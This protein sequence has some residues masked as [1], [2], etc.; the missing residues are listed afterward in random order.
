MANHGAKFVSVNLNK[1]YGQQNQPSHHSHHPHFNGGGGGSYGQAAAGRGRPK[2][3]P[4]LSVPP[5][6]NLPSLRKEHEKF[7]VLGSGGAGV[8]AGTGSGSRPN[9]S[10]VG[11]TKNVAAVAEKNEAGDVTHVVEE[12]NA[13]T[14]ASSRG[15]GS[16]MPPSARS[17]GSGFIGSASSTSRDFPPSVEKTVFLRGEDF[18]SLQAA[19]PVSSGASQKQKDGL[20]QKQKQVLREESVHD[21]ENNRSGSV[22][23]MH[24]L[25]Q[26]SRNARLVEN[27]GEGR[28]MGSGHMADQIR[29]RE[30]YLPD[31]LPLVHMNPRSDWADD[32]RD[33]GH[34]FVGHGRD[35]GFSNS[36]SYWDRDFDLP[37]PTILP[38][39]PPALNQYG[40]WG[41]RDNETGK[42]F[43]SE[44]PRTDP[45]NKEVRAPSREGEEVNKWRN[46]PVSKDGFSSQEIGGYRV[47]PGSRQAGHNNN[48]LK[49]SGAML[50]RDSAFGRQHQQRNSSMESFNNRGAERNHRDYHVTEQH[51]RYRGDNFQNNS[52]SKSSLGSSGRMPPITDPILTMGR[53]KRFS[54]S[55]RPFSE[56]P[57][58]RDYGFA[59]FGERDMFSEGIVG[60]IKR[61][62]DA[63][64]STDFYDPVRE[65]FEAE[66]EKVQKMRELEK[67]RI[68]EEQER[69]LEQVQRE[70]EERQR[71]IR[72]EEERQR[73]L[74]EEARE[75]VWRAEQEKLEAIQKAEELRI[76]REE[77]RRR[78]QLEEERRKQAAKQKL[79]ELEA[80]IAKRQAEAASKL[81]SN[82]NL[83]TAAK[84]TVVIS[85][86]V[87]LH[88]EQNQKFERLELEERESSPDVMDQEFERLELEER[89]SPG[90]MDNMV[91]GFDE[92]V[93]VVIP[94]D[95]F[96]KKIGST[97]EERGTDVGISSDEQNLLPA[98]DFSEISA[99]DSSEISAD[100]SSWKVPEESTLEVSI[101]QHAGIPYSSETSDLLLDVADSSGSATLAAQQTVSAD[102][103][104]SS[105]SANSAAAQ[106]T[107][108][109]SAD[110]ITGATSHTNNT[111]SLS[112]I[113]GQGDLPLKLQFGL[114][115]GPSLIPSPVPAIQIGS[116]QMPL[117]IHPPSITHMHQSQPSMF[118]F[119]QL[120]YTSPISQGL[121]PMAP[122]SMS[123][124][125]PNMLGHINLN[126]NMR[127]TS[128]QNVNK[129]EVPSISMNKQPSFV[130]ASPEQS[131]LSRPQQ[132]NTVLNAN[133]HAD[134]SVLR[135]D[136]MKS[137]SSSQAEEK[138][139][140]HA[141]AP[142]S[143]LPSSKARGSESH[144]HHVQPVMQPPGGER[145]FIGHRGV[146]PL[147]GGG[148][149]GRR[150]TYAVK[151]AN[152]RSFGQDY[153]MP[154]D[155]NG[156]QRR[157]RRTVQRTEFRVRENNDRRPS[158]QS[159]SSNNA[160]FEDKSNYVGKAVGVFTRSGSKRGTFVPNKIPRQRIESE[161]SASGNIVSQEV[162]SG[163]RA[164]KETAKDLSI[165]SQYSSTSHHG[166]TSLRR[167]ASEEDVDAPLQ[168]GVVRV[169][170]QPGIEAP[171]DEDDF[172]EVRSKR[173]MLNDRREQREKE[174]KAQSRVTKP[175]RKPRVSRQKDV[176][177]S[178]SHN[179]LSEPL[180]SGET[181][182]T[183]VEFT[184]SEIPP[185]ANNEVATKLT[186]AACQ[187]PIG[188]PAI[189]SEAQAINRSPHPG[190]VSLVSSGSTEREPALIFDSKNKVMSLSQTQIDEA[191]KPA[192]YD[193]H[194]SAVGSHSTSVTDPVL[195]T[196]SI[197]TKDK[198]FSSGA[199]P[200]NSLLAGEKIQ[201]GAVTSPTLL[202][203]T[204][205]V[206]SH[207]IGAPGSNRTD[208]QM[209]RNFPVSEKDNSLFFGKEKHMSDSRGP[210]QDCEAEAE[211]AAS[212]V[213]VAAISSD[214]IVGNQLSS[215][216]DTKGYVGDK[217]LTSQSSQA[218]ELLSVSLPADLCLETPSSLWPP[219]PSPQS[220]SSQMLSHFPAGPPSHFPFYEMNPLLGGPIFA[221]SP[222][223][224]SSGTQSQP[225]KSAPSSSGPLGNWQQCH[226]DVDSFYG[227]PAGYPGPFIGPPGGM[228]GVQGPPHMVVYNHF[229]PVGQYGQVGLSF[230]G[231][232]YIPS[233]KQADWKNISTS[234]AMHMGEGDINNVNMANVQQSAPNNMT[235]PIQHLAPGSPL[236]PMPPPMPMFD[237][238]PFQ[239]PADLAVQARWGHMPPSPLH[240]I[241][242]SRPS[243]Q[244]VEGALPPHVNHGH[245]SVDQ[246][247]ITNRFTESRNPTQSDKGPN[248][249]SGTTTEMALVDP[250]RSTT[251]T[252]TNTGSSGQS[253]RVQSSSGSTNAESGKIDTIENAKQHHDATS[254][255][256]PSFS[257]KNSPGGPQTSTGGYNN[258]Q[259]GGMSQRGNMGNDFSHRRMGFQG[260]GH[261]DNR[262]FHT[263][264][265]KQ[266]YVA[267]Q[268]SSSGGPTA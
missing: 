249:T 158:V 121:L 45:Y 204:S 152:T 122:Q 115:S 160:G 117:H 148:G 182:K 181:S 178:R 9:S 212:A 30:E 166:E 52:L 264:K 42:N 23:D 60:I 223:E 90:V 40:R 113:G 84:E 92:G 25:G 196:S 91:L 144:L 61:K 238:S 213:A 98:D 165:K 219:L 268:T 224:K 15:V 233:G 10:G 216:N 193:S 175:P 200:I 120:H 20:N 225:P 151:N 172:I 118:P 134:N 108:S 68:V 241:P 218:E 227:P 183:Q 24:P 243:H 36:E 111:P 201:F 203:P 209:S 145:N 105:G 95:D 21:K 114:F 51:N 167:N 33:T 163:D 255:K 262:G 253:A 248:F 4:K 96:E 215:V 247:I 5:P 168:T 207:G 191:M 141:V 81:I 46:S 107:V 1:S 18:P 140:R 64:K 232:T 116:I 239:S 195:P 89:E 6:L 86:E 54:N 208:V 80:M 101:S 7:D 211:A 251:N 220:S 47:D 100:S 139:Q 205:R 250:L 155:S 130:P 242:V 88:L 173:Q 82:E 187:P 229:A 32:E 38:H 164:S 110:V 214:E 43:S 8:G 125:Q 37:R 217:H 169:F 126:Q 236:L 210:L 234:S 77:E 74:E 142:R 263:A 189:S 221:F 133:S 50:N 129:A 49:D 62:K 260:R 44:V 27:G 146:G 174:I 56:D 143:Y 266:I 176:V 55:D 94:S 48:M 185:F 73:R 190:S 59:S 123:F 230:M 12:I 256:T 65:S 17:N 199:S 112:C 161:S 11:W 159:V 240:S 2:I 180:S 99:D 192:R 197:L 127:D 57:F 228:P 79:L 14:G 102:I 104:D 16:Y 206:V 246:S 78:M 106:Q 154:A 72:E 157:P 162:N 198:S 85:R 128:T 63:A 22:A 259:R 245:H 3:I 265:V 103:T 124:V 39:K 170:K 66:L 257:R 53:D 261:V 28:V 69:A 26:S 252:N 87:D 150:F 226:S 71:K 188:T 186:S 97:M 76:A 179:K 153:D 258:Y 41:Q 138:G 132:L 137:E 222:H 13:V 58:S 35:T 237:V 119:G 75:A 93:Q 83:E 135:N 156:F 70:Q 194:I 29:K 177:V 19:R 267:K 131:N 254:F 34:G 149:R 31:P 147:S 202:P 184:S 171:S 244:Q 109:A 136:K 235:P 231:T 67:Q